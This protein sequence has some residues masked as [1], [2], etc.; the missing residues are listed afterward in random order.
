M[1]SL[2]DLGGEGSHSP[3]KR[4]QGLA[5]TGRK[6]PTFTPASVKTEAGQKAL[7]ESI[8]ETERLV[9]ESDKILRRHHKER[10]EEIKLGDCP[11]RLAVLDCV[12][13][14]IGSAANFGAPYY[15]GR[16]TCLQLGKRANLVATV[17]TFH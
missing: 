2:P 14:L 10:E 8:S 7:R 9:D 17:L 3:G 4:T 16:N 15:L 13:A 1:L 5:R 12:H 11:E 6:L